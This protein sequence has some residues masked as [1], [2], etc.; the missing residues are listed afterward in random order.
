MST[1]S[2]AFLLCLCLAFLLAIQ[3]ASS[4]VSPWTLSG[5][6]AV[7]TG[8]SKGIGKSVVEQLLSLNCTVLTCS[9]NADELKQLKAEMAEMAET[10]ATSKLTTVV[11]DVSTEEGQAALLSAAR[12]M[13]SSS[14]AGLDILV[15]NVGR[16]IRK[17]TMAY[18][19]TEVSDIFA[20]NL[21]SAFNLSRLFHP[22]LKKPPAASPSSIINVGS[23]AGVTS[24]NSGS[25]YAMTKAAMNQLTSNLACE[26]AQ[27][28]IRV[29]CVAPWYIATPLAK[30]VLS[31][32]TYLKS[33]LDRTPANRVG[34][35]E[36]VASVVAFLALPQAAYLT[37]QVICVDGGFVKNGFGFT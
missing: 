17:P 28:G 27:H 3:P 11:A 30:Q 12:K 5:K 13:C 15:N 37:G 35:P 31:N 7:V 9:R 26:W 4:A 14:P 10:G 8:G 1:A 21:F 29:N 22:L 34:Q 33:V 36:E 19:A 16:N 2:S 24:M 23:V 25:I 6:T 18:S 20:T 32:E